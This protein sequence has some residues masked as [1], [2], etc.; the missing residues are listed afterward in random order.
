[1]I[2]EGSFRLLAILL[3]A[4]G[5]YLTRYVPM[6][7]EIKIENLDEWLQHSSIAL[8]SALLVTN[9]ISTPLNVRDLGTNIFSLLFVFAT[10]RKWENLGISILTGVAA[11]L[12]LSMILRFS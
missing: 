6:K 9:L 2:A 10:Y 7:L 4:V 8:I 3:V 11:H 12:I 5:T 1:M